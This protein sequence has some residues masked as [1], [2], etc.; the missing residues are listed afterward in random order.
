MDSV[1]DFRNPA[2]STKSERVQ[3]M[4]VGTSPRAGRVCQD[5]VRRDVTRQSLTLSAIQDRAFDG[6][7]QTRRSRLEC[8]GGKIK[9]IPMSSSLSPLQAEKMQVEDSQYR[10]WAGL[11]PR[12]QRK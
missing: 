6:T 11:A 3:S 4:S 12:W 9:G 1:K 10:K 7:D 8:F 2:G 5:I